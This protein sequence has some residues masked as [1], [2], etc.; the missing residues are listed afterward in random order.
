MLL[1]AF[2]NGQI[3]TWLSDFQ[4]SGDGQNKKSKASGKKPAD[5]G[6]LGNT[7]FNIVDNFDMFTNPH[8][9]D[10]ITEEDQA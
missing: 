7:Q 10:N 5:I 8:G 4:P 9:L 2:D 3:R 1:A 6:D